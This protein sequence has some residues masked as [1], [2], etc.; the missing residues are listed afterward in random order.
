[1]PITCPSS[2]QVRNVDESQACP[3]NLGSFSPDYMY[4]I[5]PSL[6]VST[7]PCLVVSTVPSLVV[8]TGPNLAVKT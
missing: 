7:G 3:T 1:M 8:S 4:R 5:V 2:D 6:V